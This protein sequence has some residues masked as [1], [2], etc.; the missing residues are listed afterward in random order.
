MIEIDRIDKQLEKFDKRLTKNEECLQETNLKLERN[1]V[2]TESNT[3]MMKKLTATLEDTAGAMKDI[4]YV[5]KRLVEDMEDVKTTLKEQDEKIACS[6]NRNKIDVRDMLKKYLPWAV[7]AIY[8]AL[9]IGGVL[10]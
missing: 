3:E 10:P 6:E 4:S 1:N 7:V 9:S 8:I 5:N 2:L